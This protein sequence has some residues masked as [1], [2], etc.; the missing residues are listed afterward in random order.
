MSAQIISLAGRSGALH[1]DPAMRR[2]Y[3]WAKDWAK[4]ERV[5]E[6]LATATPAVPA[7]QADPLDEM[8]KLLRRI[9]R[10]LTRLAK[11]GAA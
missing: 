2:L 10:R 4:A 3:H 1:P 5:R 6:A 9:D 8:V 11:G 7:P